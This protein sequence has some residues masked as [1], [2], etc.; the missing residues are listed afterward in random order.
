MRGIAIAAA[1]TAA[2]LIGGAGAFAADLAVT[3]PMLNAPRN[4][5]C[6]SLVDFFTSACQVAAY[7]VRFYGAIDVGGSYM[8]NPTP[9]DR[10]PGPGVGYFPAK[11]SGAHGAG[12]TFAPN[13]LSYSNLGLQIKEQLGAGWSFV[14][15]LEAGFVPPTFALGDNPGSLRENAGLTLNQQRFGADGS[16]QGTFYNQLGFAGISHDTFGSLTFGRQNDL[17]KD[18][19]FAYDAMGNAYGFSYIGVFGQTAAGG[20]TANV[21]STTAVKYRVNV[22]N[23]RFGAFSQVGGYDLGNASN[24]VF[25]GDVGGD[26]KVGPGALSVDA[27]GSFT[28]DAVSEALTQAP[29]TVIG[30]IPNPNTPQSLLVTISNNTS[31]MLAAKY[32]WDRLR[33]YAGYEW[34]QFAPPSDM[35]TSFTDQSGTFLCNSNSFGNSPACLVGGLPTTISNTA[36]NAQ[37]KIQQTAWA[38]ARYALTSSVD[39]VGSYYH[40]DTSQFDNGTGQIAMTC[41]ANPIANGNCHGTVD[42]ASFL[43]DWQ[44][45]PKWDTYLG[46]L[47]TKLN[48]GQ[49]SGFLHDNNWATTAGVRFRW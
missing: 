7:G 18:V 19:A 28:K 3:A 31:A 43:V 24:G 49:A 30:G 33:L 8:T 42:S 6:T 44:I 48:G 15:Q 35:I 14:G 13:A 38:G 2:M 39:V 23:L 10:L 17:A 40:V 20:D 12:F 41:A 34:I 4:T 25:Q 29:G 47:Y 22:S 26:W 46:T 5:A 45:A 9:L 1:S 36:F 11:N 21:K 37:K 27:V 16:S 32:T